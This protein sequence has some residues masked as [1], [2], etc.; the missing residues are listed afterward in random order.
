MWKIHRKGMV[1]ST[2]LCDVYKKQNR[3]EKY[4][5]QSGSCLARDIVNGDSL[6][7][8]SKLPA[9]IQHGKVVE[10]E[11]RKE[12]K[13][14]M[15][16]THKKCNIAPSGLV[17]NKQRPFLAAS[18]DDIRT[19]KCCRTVVVE[20]KCPFK[21][22]EKHPR[23]A[24]LH[25]NVGGIQESDGSYTL[26]QS[27]R[28]Y[29]QIQGA[30]AATNTNMCDFV[31]FTLNS[32]MGFSG[33][34]FIVEIAFN[35]KFWD[36]V[37]DR[38]T[39]FYLT[40]VLPLVFSIVP[41]HGILKSEKFQC[42]APTCVDESGWANSDIDTMKKPV[43]HFLNE[44]EASQGANYV[45]ATIKEVPLFQEDLDSL[46]DKS[47]VTDNIVVTFMR[48]IKEQFGI[49]NN[50]KM[51]DSIFYLALMQD[52]SCNDQPEVNFHR[53]SSHLTKISQD[54]ILVVPIC[55]HHHW[56]MIIFIQ[57][58][59]LVMDS[60][61]H[62]HETITRNNE[63]DLICKFFKWNDAEVNIEYKRCVLQTPQ[64]DNNTDCGIYLLLN[65]ATFLSHF[66][67]FLKDKE[68]F[69]KQDFKHWFNDVHAKQERK[70]MRDFIL[71][72]P[73]YCI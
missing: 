38:I 39:Q 51:A 49:M 31:V 62:R 7:K 11:A 2:K 44:E 19:C 73:S 22:K 35:A 46:L 26:S 59:A 5:A 8:Y 63:I 58:Y 18:P 20:Y 43:S 60:L 13:K 36:A 40:W 4:P 27:H 3:I 37:V 48:L 30:M 9:Q 15:M 34:I 61:S 45:I 29:F 41:V 6:D 55:A 47:E 25:K 71:H 28:Y 67:L 56:F 54:D 72:H 69:C 32:E 10:N 64:Q 17:I 70:R 52:I 65:L 68:F 14:M 33:S 53:A 1:T 23:E 21:S 42:D 50:L 66:E 16:R 24:F 57:D 12:Y